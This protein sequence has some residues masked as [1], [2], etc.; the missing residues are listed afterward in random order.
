MVAAA[1]R[2]LASSGLDPEQRRLLDL[3]ADGVV[4]RYS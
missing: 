2:R 1:K 4:Q 3:V